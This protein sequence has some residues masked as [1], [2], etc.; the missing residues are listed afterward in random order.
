MLIP[1]ICIIDDFLLGDRVF[2]LQGKHTISSDEIFY[3]P[4]LNTEFKIKEILPSDETDTTS[5]IIYNSERLYTG[6]NLEKKY[7]IQ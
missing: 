1:I 2:I 7:C 5:V 3:C 6:Y 4:E